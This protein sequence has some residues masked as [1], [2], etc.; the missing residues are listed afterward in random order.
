MQE[1]RPTGTDRLFVDTAGWMALADAGDHAHANARQVRDALLHDGG[2]LI[3]TDY[4]AD[5]T[6]TLIRMRLGLRA[7]AQW[8]AQVDA[9]TRIRWEWI[10][11][12]RAEKARAWFFGWAD[13]TFSFTDCTSFVVMDE[14]GLK[15]AL[16]TDRHFR[17]AGFESL[18]T[19]DHAV[20]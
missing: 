8:W 6:L 4:V 12:T 13:K 10:D 16:T 1:F 15:K 11:P 2:V 18:P 7:A 5:E 19:A 20:T 3:T 14:L 17:Q 9:S